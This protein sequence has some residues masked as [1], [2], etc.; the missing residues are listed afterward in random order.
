MVRLPLRQLLTAIALSGAQVAALAVP[1]GVS[2]QGA[3][4]PSVAPRA[5]S[6]E[7]SGDWR[8]ATELLGSYLAMAP[9]DGQAWF[10]F[11]RMYLI[12]AQK[13]HQTGH[14]GEPNGSLLL[15]LAAIAFDHAMDLQV[16]SGFVYRGAVEMERGLV[17]MEEVGWATLTRGGTATT[18][19]APVA[20]GFVLELGA[21]LLNSC[22]A[23]GV[24]VPGSQLEML[25]SWLASVALQRRS[26]VFPVLPERLRNDSLYRREAL[27]A[28]GEDGSASADGALERAASRRPLCLSPFA[29][30]LVI[31]GTSWVATRLVRVNGPHAGAATDP[32]SVTE[33]LQ[34]APLRPS[35]WTQ[36]VE[37]V[38]L[39]AA[40][41]NV[42]LCG[43]LLA[44][45]GDP[46][47]SACGP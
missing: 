9:S 22:P 8:S 47:A 36:E 26:D 43:G 7:R 2:A 38:Y 31:P 10:Q 6:L 28:L 30:S 17:L 11:G 4:D 3:V 23:G 20:P 12:A 37:A 39:E 1:S 25:A 44:Y 33:F 34:V 15:D 46:A 21:N 27:A 35:P 40:R 19:I 14:Q 41:R 16:D 24:L 13:W 42:R 5:A 18:P 29:D 45:L 32:L